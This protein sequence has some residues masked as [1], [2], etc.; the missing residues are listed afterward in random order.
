VV[1]SVLLCANRCSYHIDRGRDSR[2]RHKHHRRPVR[3]VGLTWVTSDPMTTTRS[4]QR[5]G[6][7]FGISVSC[8]RHVREFARIGVHRRRSLTNHVAYRLFGSRK[9]RL[10]EWKLER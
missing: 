5:L 3:R 1:R 8:Y 4:P 2:G 6:L 10:E 9:K 7:G